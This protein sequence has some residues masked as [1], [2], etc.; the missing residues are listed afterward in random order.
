[1]LNLAEQGPLLLAV[2]DLHWCDRPSLLFFAYLAR[3]LE[4]Q[5]ILLLAGLREAEPGTDPA[6]LGEIAHDP[7]A[8][9]VRPG[10]LSEAAV[11][12]VIEERLARR[13]P[14]RSR[15]PAT[16]RRAAT[17]CCSASS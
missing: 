14:P 15:P 11:V 10:P 16:R 3:R 7:A 2:D 13:R 12:T 4:G 8:A 6:L 17:R 1:M 5:P 9:R